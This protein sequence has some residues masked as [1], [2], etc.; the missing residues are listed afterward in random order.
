MGKYDIESLLIDIES[1]LQAKLNLKI[2]AIEAEK[3]A[4]GDALS[5]EPIDSSSYFMQ[6]LTRDFM[7]KTRSIFFGVENIPKETNARNYR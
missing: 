7:Q 4:E 6:S 3:A 5:L 2:A 1:M